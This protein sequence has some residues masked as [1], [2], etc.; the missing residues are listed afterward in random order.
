M[1]TTSPTSPEVPGASGPADAL[2]VPAVLGARERILAASYDLFLERGVWAVGVNEII[3]ASSVAKA[4]F[5]RHFPS[6]DDLIEAFFERRQKLFTIGYLTAESERRGTTPREQLLATFEIF[7]EWFQSPDFTGCPYLRAL[8]EADPQDRVGTAS[9]AYLEDIRASV[10]AAATLMG[11][12][13]PDDF[14]RC[15]LSLMQ[16]TVVSAVTGDTHGG[17]R[18]RRL[19]ETL[20]TLHTPAITADQSTAI[21]SVSLP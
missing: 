7:D 20:I 16:G 18:M 13:D 19:G 4:T 11:L 9:R 3:S 1:T 5:Y 14:A 12:V 10:E 8:L 6:K 2:H 21:S 15:W 17:A